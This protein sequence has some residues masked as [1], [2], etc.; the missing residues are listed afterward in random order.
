M[1]I[2]EKASN[3]AAIIVTRIFL[4][5]GRESSTLPLSVILLA[6]D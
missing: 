3:T 2:N 1:A 6:L 5:L 4:L